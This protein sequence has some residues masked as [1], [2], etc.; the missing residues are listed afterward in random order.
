MK[1]NLS[2]S[3]NVHPAQTLDELLA[4]LHAHVA[5]I[6]RAAFGPGVAAT[7]FRVGMAQADE[8]LGS[9]ALPSTSG[10]SDAVLSAPPTPAAERLLATLDELKLDVVSINA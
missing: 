1:P 6:S 5:P 10:L 7:N 4:S 2:Y 8:L 9:P 3:T